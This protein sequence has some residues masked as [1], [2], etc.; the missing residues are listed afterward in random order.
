M[1]HSPDLAGRAAPSPVVLSWQDWSRQ[2]SRELYLRAA[3]SGCFS[4]RFLFPALV[5]QPTVAGE[6]AVSD[7]TLLCRFMQEDIWAVVVR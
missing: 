7:G 5:P 2:R 6:K 1:E 4:L 3:L